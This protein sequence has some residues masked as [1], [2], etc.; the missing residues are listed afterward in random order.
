MA[1]K[2]PASVS[3]ETHKHVA[4]KRRNIPSKG[5]KAAHLKGTA[6]EWT[7]EEAREAGRKGGA[8]AHRRRQMQAQN[9]ELPGKARRT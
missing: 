4:D 5:G 9:G 6:H 8:T 2:K 1:K 7:V 3:V